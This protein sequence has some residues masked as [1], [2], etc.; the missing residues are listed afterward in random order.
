[1]PVALILVMAGLLF[2]MALSYD[3]NR[4]SLTYRW[5]IEDIVLGGY[6]WEAAG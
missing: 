1:M 5:Y 2:L 4:D 3:P 6:N